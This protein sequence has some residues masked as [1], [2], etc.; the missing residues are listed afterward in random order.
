[1]ETLLQFYLYIIYNIY[2]IAYF[3]AYPRIVA[4]LFTTRPLLCCRPRRDTAPH[5]S[6]LRA[7]IL[8]TAVICSNMPTLCQARPNTIIV[9]KF[10]S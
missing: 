3:S 9:N 10:I 4:T 2:I 7:G 5:S 6:R 8:N 1:M